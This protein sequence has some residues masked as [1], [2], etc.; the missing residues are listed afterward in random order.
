MSAGSGQV[1]EASAGPEPTPPE[2]GGT[3]ADPELARPAGPARAGRRASLL[4]WWREAGSA[5]QLGAV[6]AVLATVVGA[7][8][9]VAQPLLRDGTANPPASAE[10]T[11]LRQSPSPSAPSVTPVDGP[12]LVYVV[13]LP[14]VRSGCGSSWIV[15]GPVAEGATFPA[16]ESPPDGTLGTGS[17]IGVIV[18]ET[19]GRTVVLHSLRAQVVGR[20]APSRGVHLYDS[21]CGGFLPT[22][23]LR[24]DLDDE[25]PVAVLRA[26]PGQAGADP[27]FPWTVAEND[28][29][30]YTVEVDVSQGLARFVL[31]LDWT[32]GNQRRQTTIDNDGKPF[33]VSSL[34]QVTTVLCPG[35]GD[36]WA[37]CGR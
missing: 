25:A 27:A 35:R 32:W 11:P 29:V 19:S 15:P 5:A 4:R 37:G 24:V 14:R 22:A 23:R 26:T 16:R 2:Q 28:P 21:G 30:S 31:V 34:D 20:T 13:T 17:S 33:V 36:V 7:L 6:G 18:Q 8:C 9:A 3:D 10:P 1:D 12:A